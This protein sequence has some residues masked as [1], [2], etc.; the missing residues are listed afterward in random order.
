MIKKYNRNKRDVERVLRINAWLRTGWS[1]GTQRA[2]R[3]TQ[4]SWKCIQE[5]INKMNIEKHLYSCPKCILG[6]IIKKL[7]I[8]KHLDSRCKYLMKIINK[9]NI[10]NHL[11]SRWKCIREITNKIDIKKDFNY[12]LKFV[13]DINN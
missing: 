13:R 1:R 12:A 7:N 8:K 2:S 11:N 6:K 9:M 3:R 10:E 4:L 5:I